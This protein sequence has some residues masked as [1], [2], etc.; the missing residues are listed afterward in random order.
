MI[1]I[2]RNIVLKLEHRRYKNICTMLHLFD[3]LWLDKVIPK[4]NDRMEI[5]IWKSR[6]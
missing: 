1:V 3:H 5:H 2:V 6:E 4:N